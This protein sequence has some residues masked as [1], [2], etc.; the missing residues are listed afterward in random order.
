MNY[1]Y[2]R[3]G[4]AVSILRTLLDAQGETN[5]SNARLRADGFC[6]ANEQARLDWWDSLPTTLAGTDNRNPADSNEPQKGAK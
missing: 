2:N 5:I 4:E 1:F 3:L 6:R